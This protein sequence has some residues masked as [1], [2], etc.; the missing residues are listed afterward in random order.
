MSDATAIRHIPGDAIRDQIEAVLTAW[1]VAAEPAA[2]AAEAL[3]DADLHGVD[4]HG[5]GLVPMYDQRRG[6]GRINVSAQ[7]KVVREK[8]A[9]ALIDAD[10][11]LGHP[12]SVQAM[13]LACDKARDAGVGLVGVRNSNHFG[14][15][16]YYSRQAAKAGMIGLA[17]THAPGSAIVPTFGRDAALGTNP[18]AFAAPARANPPFALDMATSTVAL[19][20]VRNYYRR[21]NE[22]PLGWAMDAEGRPTTDPK[23]GYEARR[24][25]P[26]GG[27][28]D[29]GSH[30]GYGL[31]MMVE[32]LCAVL[33]GAWAEPGESD[34][35]G[36][37]VKSATQTGHFFLAIDPNRLRG[38][39]A[40]G[41]DLDRMIDMLHAT[42]PVDPARPVLVAGD[43]EYATYA[44][45]SATGVPLP[46][47]LLG[48]LRDVVS[49]CNAPWL[50]G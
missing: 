24:V 47:T 11:S 14:A 35:E 22:I 18:I 4:S 1:G 3:A 50:L 13:Q 8:A 19:N 43:P 6:Q 44:E 36:R 7:P 38:G 20:K 49:R 16:G 33:T 27:T 28:R 31:A 29:L 25:A 30:K 21:G 45:R 32:I 40:F 37:P 12:V 10:R 39:E 2:T 42:P 41:E 5:V 17:M 9:V 34:A 26:V 46:E 15:A 23:V 48:E